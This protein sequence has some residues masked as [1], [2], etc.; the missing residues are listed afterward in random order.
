MRVIFI[1]FGLLALVGAIKSCSEP[2]STVSRVDKMCSD[3]GY[4]WVMAGNFVKRELKAPST[5]KFPHKADAYSYLGECRHSIVGSVD[6]HNSFGA[7]IRTT[8]SVTMVYLKNEDKWR[9]EN[10]QI[11]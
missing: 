11:H 6:S 8:F 1:I 4:A 3:E 7:M 9:A 10:L 2:R 5:A